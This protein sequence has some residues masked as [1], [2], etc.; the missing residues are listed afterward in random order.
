MPQCTNG[1]A[2]LPRRRFQ[3]RSKNVVEQVTLDE[4]WQRDI[5]LGLWGRGVGVEEFSTWLHIRVVVKTYNSFMVSLFV[6]RQLGNLCSLERRSR[7]GG[8]GGEGE[9]AAGL[10]GN[11]SLRAVQISLEYQSREMRPLQS[12]GV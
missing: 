12:R 7:D 8:V 4:A 11:G 5:N 9:R 6:R 2:A 1:L 10:G 3:P